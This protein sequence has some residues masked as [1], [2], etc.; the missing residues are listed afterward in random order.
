MV[1]MSMALEQL[2]QRAADTHADMSM[3]LRELVTQAGEVSREIHR[4]SYDLHPSKLAYIGLV[5]S[6]K[7][8]C[9]DLRQLHKLTI[10][11]RHDGVPVGLSQEI[12]L[13]Q[14][15]IAQECLNN[16]IRHSGSQDAKVE[17][18]GTRDEIVLRVSDTGVGFDAD[19]PATRRGLGLD[20][21]RERLRLVGG[22]ISI[23]SRPSQG[24]HITAS[25]PLGQ[26]FRA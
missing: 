13:C 21:M 10:E 24:T 12:S 5:A 15:R 9:D 18:R 22:N 11:F 3:P 25:V 2:R 16:V 1:L 17:L 4:I 8:L 26:S 6:V 14:Y 23:E 7:S 20:S 19:S